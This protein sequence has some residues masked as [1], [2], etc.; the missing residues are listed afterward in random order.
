MSEPVTLNFISVSRRAAQ[1]PELKAAIKTGELTVSKARK[2]TSVITPESQS[3]WISKAINL[4]SRALEKEVAKVLP[5]ELTPERTKYVREDRVN[6]NFG[7]KE[8]FFKKL[9]RIQ[10]LESQRRSKAVSIEETLNAMI[11][12]YLEKKDPLE[13]ARRNINAHAPVPGHRDEKSKMEESNKR[14]P[15]RAQLRHQVNLRDS[16]KCAQEGCDQQRWLDI[17]H[18]IPVSQGGQNTLGNLT[19]L[20]R[21]HHKMEH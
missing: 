7:L 14:K 1:I 2:I 17:H 16:G 13:K 4:T 5:Q 19:T 11:E 12:L 21:G 18:I 8:E 6:L 20:C 3:T 9:K 15:F 10:D